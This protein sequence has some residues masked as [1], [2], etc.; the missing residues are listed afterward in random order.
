MIFYCLILPVN[1][2]IINATTNHLPTI[3][4]LNEAALPA[5]SSVTLD[6]LEHFLRISDYFRILKFE[7]NITGFLIALIPGKPYNSMNYKWFEKEYKTFMYVDRI[8]IAPQ[9]H[10]NGF[11]RTFYDDL[12]DYSIDKT[13]RITCEVNIRPMN[14][15]SIIFHKKYGF[16]EVGTQK[17]EDGNKE[18]SLMVFDL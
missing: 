10:G 8:V 15:G 13:S 3:R 18:V 14:E 2:T 11:G 7:D 4:N 16:N 12:S 6:N 1:F 9:F 5:V 17:T